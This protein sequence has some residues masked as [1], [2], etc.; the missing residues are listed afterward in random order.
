MHEEHYGAEVPDFTSCPEHEP[1]EV[2]STLLR[3]ETK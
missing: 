2:K 1:K 3:K